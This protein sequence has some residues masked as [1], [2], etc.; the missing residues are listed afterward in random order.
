[1]RRDPA[2]DFFESLGIERVDPGTAGAAFRHQASPAQYPNMA[3]YGRA[4]DWKIRSNVASGHFSASQK[5]EDFPTCRIGNGFKAGYMCICDIRNHFVTNKWSSEPWQGLECRQVDGAAVPLSLKFDTKRGARLRACFKHHPYKPPHTTHRYGE[6]RMLFRLVMVCRTQVNFG[7]G[8]LNS[9][10]GDI[11]SYCMRKSVSKRMTGALV[12]DAGYFLEVL[13][14]HPDDLRR[15][16]HNVQQHPGHTDFWLIELREIDGRA[17][18]TWSVGAPGRNKH[19][20]PFLD[21]IEQT[22]PAPDLVID[23]VRKAIAAG[24]MAESQ[25]AICAA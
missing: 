18:Q 4:A 8:A 10:L 13:E 19:H 11:L 3:R 5:V 7:A 12:W 1:V 2:V 22:G 14:G 9:E 21:T 23:Y 15:Y 25:P 16:W 24:V 20:A 6:K 17:Y